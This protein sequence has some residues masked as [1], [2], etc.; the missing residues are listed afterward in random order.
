MTTAQRQ[1]IVDLMQVTVPEGKRD[2]VEVS[3]FEITQDQIRRAAIR[4]P[5]RAYTEPGMYTK[6]VV[7]GH[8]WMSD[9]YAERND[10]REPIIQ[11]RRLEVT[12]GRALVSGLGIGMVIQALLMTSTIA[13]VDVIEINSDVIALVGPH[14]QE[15]AERLGKTITIHEGDVFDRK[16]MFGPKDHWHIAWHDVWLDLNV[17]NL[18][19]MGRVARSYNRYADWSGFWGKDELIRM[20]KRDRYRFGY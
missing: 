18:E 17:D 11:A 15:M 20:R 9:T 13:H 8:L 2:N 10:H 3:R 14:Y 16:S 6:L 12:D 7:G 19:D 5:H 1:L 4:D